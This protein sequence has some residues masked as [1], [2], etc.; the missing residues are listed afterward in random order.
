MSRPARPLFLVG[1]PRTGSTLLTTLLLQHPDIHMHGEL[2]HPE[3]NERRG[4]HALRGRSKAWFDPARD[5]ALEFLDSH[6]FGVPTDYR[7]RPVEV[8]GVKVFADHCST[9]G[10]ADL[11]PRVREHYPTAHVLHIR[12]DDYLS[13][14]VSLEFATRSRQWVSWS[15]LQEPRREIEPFA[16]P[17][18]RARAFFEDMH[19]ADAYFALHF[20]GPGYLAVHYE[21][22]VDDL[23]GTMAGVFTALGVPPREVSAVTEKQLDESDLSLVLN[24]AALAEEFALFR[25]RHEIR[26]R[27]RPAPAAPPA[28]APTVSVPAVA[29][30]LAAR[31]L[32]E[33][34]IVKQLA[35]RGVEVTVEEVASIVSAARESLPAWLARPL[36]PHY[37]AA[38][39][40]SV[41]VT[42]GEDEPCEPAV[43]IGILPDGALR[44]LGVWASAVDIDLSRRGVCWIQLLLADDDDVAL[45]V[46]DSPIDVDVVDTETLAAVRA[47]LADI[48][49][50]ELRARA[51]ELAADLRSA[52]RLADAPE[53]LRQVVVAPLHLRG[54]MGAYRGIGRA[55]SPFP[56]VEAAVE[57]LALRARSGDP[58]GAGEARWPPWRPRHTAALAD[59]IPPKPTRSPEQTAAHVGHVH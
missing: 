36:E 37:A 13:V 15:H 21:D 5:D 8:V 28:S 54:V 45:Q 57:A 46:L 30:R 42:V 47:G 33:P 1:N 51:I 41:P 48:P 56:S 22:L 2:F 50:E 18:E 32:R 43:G 40:L 4:T 14:L 19:R 49:R 34:G 25:E 53:V 55:R 31:G 3:V 27:E 9:G 38:I 17:R 39:L 26:P 20:A 12:R 52:D 6:V 29:L 23:D 24:L 10:A 35:G 7:G 44:V 59:A 16:V 58:T 11:F